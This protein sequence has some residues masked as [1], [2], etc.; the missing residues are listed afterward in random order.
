MQQRLYKASLQ[1]GDVILLGNDGVEVRAYSHVLAICEYFTA[2]SEFAEGKKKEYKFQQFNSAQL[3]R[4][5]KYLHGIKPKRFNSAVMEVLSYF[6][7]PLDD[8]VVEEKDVREF[9]VDNL[10]QIFSNK[11]ISLGVFMKVCKKIVDEGLADD[12]GTTK[13]IEGLKTRNK[14]KATGFCNYRTLVIARML[15][16]GKM[17]ETMDYYDGYAPEEILAELIET[18]NDGGGFDYTYISEFISHLIPQ[19]FDKSEANR[20]YNGVTYDN[21][22]SERARYINGILRD[23]GEKEISML[24]A[25][26]MPDD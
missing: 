21:K 11:E 23:E 15:M 6:Q 10:M 9:S 4:L 18:F 13:W 1:K 2:S 26:Q 17:Q 16:S 7:A 5:V 14:I 22:V 25:S 24:E 20:K 12:E 19:I 3:T 8:V